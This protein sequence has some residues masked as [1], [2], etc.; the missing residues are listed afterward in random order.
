MEIKENTYIIKKFK[1][2]FK[3][4]FWTGR[5]SAKSKAL[6]VI[7]LALNEFRDNLPEIIRNVIRYDEIVSSNPIENN[8]R[9][10]ISK[11]EYYRY[12]G[13]IDEIENYSAN[14]YSF[15]LYKDI[16]EISEYGSQCCVIP[17]YDWIQILQEWE[18]FLSR[19]YR[20]S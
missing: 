1:L 13:E 20:K 14:I 19:N 8:L 10:M 17:I 6:E 16:V 11:E 15:H 5:I 2:K 12:W 3:R 9:G 7:G 4:S 18:Y